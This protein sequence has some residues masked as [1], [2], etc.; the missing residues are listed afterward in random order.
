MSHTH[1]HTHTYTHTTPCLTTKPGKVHTHTQKKIT[2]DPYNHLQF[3][4]AKLSC[5]SQLIK[6]DS[7]CWKTPP[8]HTNQESG[9][10]DCTSHQLH[11]CT[12]NCMCV[13]PHVNLCLCVCPDIPPALHIPS[14]L[15]YQPCSPP[16]IHPS[17][18]PS[19]L[20]PSLATAV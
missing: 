7:L 16:H 13:C 9:G 8:N 4:F 19:S 20:P 11:V 10:T 12:C 6:S 18:H 15:V 2:N 14:H 1:T 5:F 17:I 3:V